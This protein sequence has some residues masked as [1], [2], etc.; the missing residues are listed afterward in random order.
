MDRAATLSDRR[1]IDLY[2]PKQFGSVFDRFL[3]Q[4]INI[5]DIDM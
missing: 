4:G 2:R 3:N 5:F 1:K